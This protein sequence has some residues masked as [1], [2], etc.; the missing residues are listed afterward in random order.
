MVRS[1]AQLPMGHRA[2]R[3]LRR[4]KY[5]HS[6]KVAAMD[7]HDEHDD[8]TNDGD[9]VMAHVREARPLTRPTSSGAV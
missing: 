6:T 9:P 4:D 5:R 3:H 7:A 1:T 8:H 2:G